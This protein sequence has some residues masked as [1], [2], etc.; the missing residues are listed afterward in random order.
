MTEIQSDE[1]ESLGLIWK[2]AFEL[3]FNNLYRIRFF[4]FYQ[5]RQIH[6]FQL[7]S[8]FCGYMLFWKMHNVTCHQSSAVS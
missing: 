6:I 3:E 4:P 7:R 5:K 8:G 1:F 2:Q